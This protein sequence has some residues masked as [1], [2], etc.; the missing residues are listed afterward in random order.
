MPA[1]ATCEHLGLTRTSGSV[2]TKNTSA[3][4]ELRAFRKNNTDWRV[5]WGDIRERKQIKTK[6]RQEE[7]E[8]RYLK[9]CL[10]KGLGFLSQI[11][12]TWHLRVPPGGL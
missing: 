4:F 11:Q 7:A 3:P 8:V 5:E 6:A 12:V 10:Q 1:H 2:F 9:V